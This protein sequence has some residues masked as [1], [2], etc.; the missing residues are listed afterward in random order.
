MKG[1]RCF[2]YAL[3]DKKYFAKKRESIP[4]FVILS[5]V[6]G[7]EGS[8]FWGYILTPSPLKG[9]SLYKQRES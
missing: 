9:Y 2:D 1:E 6:Y 7:V 3:H 4:A 5:G 8:F